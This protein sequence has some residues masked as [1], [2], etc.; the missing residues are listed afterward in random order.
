MSKNKSKD[1][2]VI[3][4][5]DVKRSKKTFGKND[6][7]NWTQTKCTA[8]GRCSQI[9]PVNAITIQKTDKLT[10]RMQAAPCSQACP[11]G[12]DGSRYARFIAEGKFGEAAA[13]MREKVPFPL[14]LGHICK[15]PCES[16]CQR[17]QYEGSLQLRALKRFAASNDSGLWQQKIKTAPDSG[18][19]V[20]VVGAG[21]AGLST[22][23][24]LTLLGHKVT[25]FEALPDK[26]GKMLSSIPDYQLPKNV[27]AD[28]V[29]IIENL[30]VIIKTNSTVESTKDLLS[31]G[32]DAVALAIGVK[33]WGKS[34]KLP[35]P[36]S[37][38]KKVI[39]GTALS[40]EIEAGRLPD[41]GPK[42]IVLGGG[43][44]AFKIALAAAQGGAAEVHIFG[45]EHTGDVE[46]ES[47]DVDDALSEGVIVHSSSMFYRVIVEDD[48]VIG[49]GA[50]KIRA[51]GYDSGG[52]VCYDTLPLEEE[53]FE[54]DSIISTLKSEDI[55]LQPMGVSPGIFAAGDAVNEQRSVIE[56]V[57]AARWVAT[58]I[59]RYLGGAGD[60]DQRLAP[61]ESKK[62]L[63]PI[64]DLKR[65]SPSPVPTNYLKIAD[66]SLAASELTFSPKAAI[67]DAERC[68]K[69]DLS[70]NLQDYNLN[71]NVCVFCGR[72]IE[73]CMWNAITTGTGYAAT[74][75][76]MEQTNQ[77]NKAKIYSYVL[78]I[79]VVAITI[80]IAAAI[81]S[82]LFG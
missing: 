50:L 26:G 9:C 36:G 67:A 75:E 76:A 81:I 80:M 44:A 17:R 24:Y 42:V 47:W 57:A 5:E 63:T 28:E 1:I 68:L 37:E 61:E 52:Q 30:G 58:A 72:C 25:I 22:S 79:I 65:R 74:S 60:L 56:S 35:I 34:I 2:T 14:V 64:R 23:Y 12:V 3:A 62:A 43:S 40:G 51:L 39:K 41:L 32:Y 82:K 20:A 33:G 13:V 77:S 71:T 49:V 73:N 10:K 11:A 70:Y 19:K 7:F 48:R 45:Q 4:A 16:E 53:I 66:G 54:A 18:R 69:C 46:A 15:R 8:C 78:T 6:E 59:D 29:S 38:H 21:P 55:T 31:E 27:V